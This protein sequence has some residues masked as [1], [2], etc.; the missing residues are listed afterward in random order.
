MVGSSIWGLLHKLGYDNLIG[1]NKSDLDLRNQKDVEFFFNKEK[2]DYVIIAAAKVGGIVANNTFRADFIYDNLQ[3]QNNII[4]QS[5]LNNVKKLLFLGSSCIYPR[6][7][8]QPIKEEYL[9]D[10]KLEFTNEPY[11]IAKI[12]GIKM[13]E[14]Y[15]RQHNCNFISIMP[16]NLYGI[17]DN[18]DFKTSHVLPALIR[19]FY[20]GKCLIDRNWDSIIKDLNLPLIKD[21]IANENNI[22]EILNDIGI[23]YN[24]KKSK[25][26][27]TLWGTGQVY[28]EFLYVDDLANAVLHIIKNIDAKKLYDDFKQ[29]HINIGTGE[30]L[31]I[32]N[33]AELISQIIGYNGDINWDISKPDGTLRK[34]LDV[35]LLN[36]IKW[37]NK[38]SLKDGIIKVY[39]SYIDK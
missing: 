2:P 25:V 36:Q 24:Q 7:C 33:L 39:K 22:I 30:D 13:C 20:L 14:N 28:R 21:G 35:S 32:K 27:I 12:A 29:T 38:I 1:V 23:T 16:T 8:N 17:N 19:K 4:H 34:K 3:I 31:T 26:N 11:A 10:G 37:Y 9:L 15:Y 6:D 5:Y 18:F